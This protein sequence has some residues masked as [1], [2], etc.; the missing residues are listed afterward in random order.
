MIKPSKVK[1]KKRRGLLRRF[2]RRNEGTAAIEFAIVSLPFFILLF[3]TVES[4]VA[5]FAG[6]VLDTAV[7]DSSRLIRTGQ[8][9]TQG[10]NEADFTQTVCE[11]AVMFLDCENTMMIDV[12]TYTDFNDADFTDPIDGDGNVEDDDFDFDMGARNEIVVVRVY[13]PWPIVTDYLGAFLSNVSGNKRLLVATS[14]F[15][16]EPF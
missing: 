8:A 9:Q 11:R 2:L 16:N 12:R 1:P 13:Y 6:Q 15:R 3:A 10:F 14:A 4:F 5:V 7:A